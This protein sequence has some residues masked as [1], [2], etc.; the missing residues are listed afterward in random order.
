MRRQT[1]WGLSLVLLA[2]GATT[3]SA[4]ANWTTYGGNDWNQRY[5]T[6]AQLNIPGSNALRTSASICSTSTRI[7]R[8]HTSRAGQSVRC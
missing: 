8:H 3:L 6:L 1:Q 2:A 4:Q 5:S 7:G